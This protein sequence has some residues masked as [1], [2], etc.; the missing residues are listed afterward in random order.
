MYGPTMSAFELRMLDAE[1]TL[2][3][4]R[5]ARRRIAALQQQ[6]RAMEAKVARAP[7]AT[8]EL[9][10]VYNCPRCNGTGRV[11]E[12][13]ETGEGDGWTDRCPRCNGEGFLVEYCEVELAELGAARGL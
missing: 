10:D 3:E 9:A 13:N 5:A 12:Y 7:V 8:A 11:P 2:A 4:E 6:V 1:L